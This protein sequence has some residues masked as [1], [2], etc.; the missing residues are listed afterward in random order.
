MSDEKDEKDLL[1]LYCSR[2]KDFKY[3][4]SRRKRML[5]NRPGKI[6]DL[7]LNYFQ[8]ESPQALNKIE[9]NRA[10]NAWETYVGRVASE[11]SRAL[12]VRKD[13]LVVQVAD[14]LWMQQ[15]HLLKNE[16]LKKYRKDFP[17][18]GLKD[19]FFTRYDNELNASTPKPAR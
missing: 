18:L 12:R 14:T 19:I 16:L 7:L 5:E 9:E 13:T 10:L 2:V 15:L 17:R 11:H 4:R 8:K 3:A 1:K 6:S